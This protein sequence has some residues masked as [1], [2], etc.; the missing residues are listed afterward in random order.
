VLHH[1]I[2]LASVLILTAFAVVPGRAAEAD[3][4]LPDDTQMVMVMKVDQL[5]N[6]ALVKEYIPRTFPNFLHDGFPWFRHFGIDPLKDLTRVVAAFP[7]ETAT[8]KGL[9]IAGGRFNLPAIQAAAETKAKKEEGRFRIHQHGKRFLYELKE[10]GE[11]TVFA[12]FLDETTLALAFLRDY[13]E[14]AI[15]KKDGKRKSDVSKNMETLIAKIDPMQSFWLAAVPS[16]ALQ[17]ALAT[18]PETEHIF[19]S[20]LQVSG[21]LDVSD[22]LRMDF[23]IQTKD[24]KTAVEVRQFMEGIKS[25]LSLAALSLEAVDKKTKGPSL[26]RLVA[27]IK[28]SSVKEAVL[29]KGAVSKDEIEKYQRE[30]PKP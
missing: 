8:K 15:A 21:G 3:P 28:L 25:I 11:D 23:V 6:S 24:A 2:E 19:R 12:C 7:L 20:V 9:L 14:E 29:I 26:T 16:P 4:L 1:R 22:S 18:S 13:L 30:K 10:P 17:K 5:L 27:A